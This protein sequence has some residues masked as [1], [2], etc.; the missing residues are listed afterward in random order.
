MKIYKVGGCVRD[1][2]LGH[3]P[4]DVDY[5]VVGSTPEE[6]LDHGFEQVGAAFPVFLKNGEEYALARKERKV[7][8]GYHGFDV[9]FD[10]TVT[11]EEDLYR[12]DLTINSMAMD[13]TTNEIIDPYGGKQDLSKG[14]LRHTSTAFAEDPVRVLRTARFSARYA[15]TVDYDT[16]DLM[17]SVV[18]ELDFVSVERIWTEF[19]KGLVCPFPWAMMKTLR[20]CNAF[21]NSKVMSP[22]HKWSGEL[23]SLVN[24]QVPLYVPFAMVAIGFSSVTDYS[25]RKIPTNIAYIS[26][27]VN[28]LGSKIAN[29]PQL[30]ADYRLH[31]LNDL[32]ALHT[33]TLIHSIV[34]V[35]GWLKFNGLSRDEYDVIIRPA[36]NRD[37]EAIKR[38]DCATI[39]QSTDKAWIARAIHQAR[40]AVMEP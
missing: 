22:Y 16:I 23:M 25:D 17:R 13:M 27:K 19:E 7:A 12:R 8:A 10:P 35:L 3:Q 18:P 40:T 9:V 11:L 20:D 33:P 30:G 15:F 24:Q 39:A 4:K 32:R 31:L 36:I 38:V 34:D 5:V 21:E 26:H 14:I 2:L 1:L 29:Y 6:M 28:T 37:I